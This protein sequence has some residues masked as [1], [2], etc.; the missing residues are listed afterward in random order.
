[1][2]YKARIDH[3]IA[4]GIIGE[5][6]KAWHHRGGKGRARTYRMAIPVVP[7]TEWEMTYD[8]ALEYLATAAANVPESEPTITQLSSTGEEPTNAH[9]SDRDNTGSRVKHIVV[10]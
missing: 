9:D 2:K 1:M 10:D 7:D 6:K 3:A 8:Q 5:V 4:E